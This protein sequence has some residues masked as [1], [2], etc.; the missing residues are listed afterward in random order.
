M[1][2]M[3]QKADTMHA[4]PMMMA[5][6]LGIPMSRMGSGTSWIPDAVT[7]PTRD[8]MRGGWDL[9]GHGFLFGQYDDQG[10]TRGAH[11]L[12]S[13]N[14]A[15]LLATRAIGSASRLQFRTMLSL[16]ALGV[17]DRGYPLLL[18]TGE[19]YHGEPLHDRQHP[20]D[21][22]MELGALYDHA[23]SKTLALSLYAAPSGEP[24][25]G[26]V[27]FMHRPSSMDDPVAPIGH[28]WQDATH[29]SFGVLTA[30]VFSR[31]WKLEGS[32]FN[33]RE[34]DENRWDFDRIRLDS[35]SGR[36]T[37]N[38]AREWSLSA[39]Y[40]YLRSP[41]ALDPGTSVH[42]A[43]ASVMNGRRIGMDGQWASTFVWGANLVAGQRASNSLLAE[44]ELVVDARN[45]L[46]ARAEWVQKSASELV[47]PTSLG[48]AP[49]RQ[50][51]LAH[52]SVGY[53][54]EVLASHGATLGIGALGTVNAVPSELGGVYG[55]R[56][57]L[58]AMVFVRLR[59]TLPMA[60]AAMGGRRMARSAM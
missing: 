50:F 30:G 44:S 19:S 40:G 16:D 53:V 56:A 11:Q 33:G 41:E 18:Q 20:H 9:M 35:W 21:F 60:P 13:L 15:M 25:L 22:F 47:L 31:T 26:P 4:M 48:F 55:S 23:L 6:V 42:R 39:S 1:K 5:G 29:T 49:G 34:P 28:H 52:V 54:R 46:L 51:G 12:G 45:T 43:T 14:W 8:V 17:T 24:A 37:V 32:Y 59:P 58:G 7:L 10:G 57:P 36:L 27:A 3:R 38:P 2:R